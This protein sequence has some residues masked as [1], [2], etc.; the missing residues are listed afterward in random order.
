M[1]SFVLFTKLQIIRTSIPSNQII[2]IPLRSNQV[3]RTSSSNRIIKLKSGGWFYPFSTT[4]PPGPVKVIPPDQLPSFAN[5]SRTAEK[6]V[7]IEGRGASM[8]SQTSKDDVIVIDNF[9]PA[10]PRN[11]ALHTHVQEANKV[12]SDRPTVDDINVIDDKK[13]DEEKKTISN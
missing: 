11:V 9:T 6:Q 4:K 12:T 1:L 10:S 13:E 5:S 2:R 8:T 3:I 7:G